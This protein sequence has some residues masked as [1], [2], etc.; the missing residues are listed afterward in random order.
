MYTDNIFV[1]VFPS[2]ACVEICT[3]WG[4]RSGVGVALFCFYFFSDDACFF[5]FL[6]FRFGFDLSLSSCGVVLCGVVCRS[7][8]SYRTSTSRFPRSLLLVGPRGIDVLHMG[9]P[10][11][12]VWGSGR[13]SATSPKRQASPSGLTTRPRLRAGGGEGTLVTRRPGGRLGSGSAWCSR[14][15]RSFTRGVSWRCLWRGVPGMGGEGKEEE[16]GEG[17]EEGGGRRVGGSTVYMLVW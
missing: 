14:W 5:L 9:N 10:R 12:M 3:F 4:V 15:R 11:S 16:E 6:L 13:L 2:S 8:R 17:S 1:I 7:Y